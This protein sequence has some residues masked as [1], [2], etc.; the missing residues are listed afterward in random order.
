MD[1]PR[2]AA[3]IEQNG[4]KRKAVGAKIS[5]HALEMESQPF[6]AFSQIAADAEHGTPGLKCLLY[7]G[8]T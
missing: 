5:G 8:C 2:K 3:R 4:P 1:H 6:G 7:K